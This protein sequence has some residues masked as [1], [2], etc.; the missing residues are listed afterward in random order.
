LISGVTNSEC[1]KKKED[2]EEEVFH[3][4]GLIGYTNEMLW[5]ILTIIGGIYSPLIL[6]SELQ[7]LDE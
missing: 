2:G 4:E 3:D 5:T 7:R 6:L 1:G